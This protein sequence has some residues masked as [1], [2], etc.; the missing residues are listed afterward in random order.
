M[1]RKA[2]IFPGQGS[3]SVGMLS[4]LSHEF[5]LVK[6]VFEEASNA[7]GFDVFELTQLGPESRLN[8]TEFTQ[9]AMLSADVAVYRV[10]ESLKAGTAQVMAGH[11]LGE[12]AALVCSQSISLS[13]AALLVMRRGQIMQRRVAEG[14]GAMA[15]VIGLEDDQIRAICSE[16]STKNEQVM[17]ANYNAPGQVV[18]AGHT[19]AV[20]KAMLLAE[21]ANARMTKILAVSVPCH[22]L[23][24]K[25]ASEEF[26]ES[27]ALADFQIPSVDVISNVDLN[28]YQ[29]PEQI[30][31][32]LTEQLY[33]PVRWVETIEI[34]K[35]YRTDLFIECGPGRVL[36]GLNK[37]IDRNL[38][39]IS[40]SDPA[41][42]R[43]LD[44]VLAEEI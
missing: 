24:L 20:E 27:L 14:Q 33:S 7:V 6:S 8:K 1:S 35:S 38:K 39:S 13:Q 5:P 11:S 17:A 29:S 25:E 9:V 26:S 37:R 41:G 30:R 44:E 31:A 32:R 15:A 16:A 3:Q 40:I 21:K 18:I 36:T 4:D 19:L 10:L 22:C 2:F 43:A 28:V 23:L 12:Y 42:V 34:M